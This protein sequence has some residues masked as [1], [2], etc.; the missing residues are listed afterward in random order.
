MKSRVM[1]IAW[2]A[3]APWW[4]VSATEALRVDFVE[5]ERYTDLSLSGSTTERI[6]TYILGELEGYLKDLAANGLPP[7]HTLQITVFDLDMAGEYE[8][9]RVPN[10]TNIRFIRDVYRPRIDLGYVG[11]DEHGRVLV[12]GREPV[13]DLNYLMLA[14][15]YYTYNDPLRYE[16]A[17]LR[18]WFEARFGGRTYGALRTES[19]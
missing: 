7:S 13:S 1:M 12:E 18:R 5:P 4:S 2:L 16:K 3:F 9:W 19:R 15:P 6:Q 11:R 17:M 14:D 8:P 10:L